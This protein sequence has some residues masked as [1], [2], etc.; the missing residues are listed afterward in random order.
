MS[1]P[2]NIFRWAM[3]HAYA[4]CAMV[5]IIAS[6]TKWNAIE[7]FHKTL[8]YSVIIPEWAVSVLTFGVPFIELWIGCWLISGIKMKWAIYTALGLLL[9]L[10]AY[11]TIERFQ[12]N[13]VKCNCLGELIAFKDA[14]SEITFGI[15]RNFV[16]SIGLLASLQIPA[17]RPQEIE[18]HAIP[19]QNTSKSVHA[20]FTLVELL[21][22]IGV[23]AVLL[24]LLL[25]ALAGFRNKAR[26]SACT[27][28]LR[29]IG[30]GAITWASGHRGFVSLDAQVRI[31]SMQSSEPR[32]VAEQLFDPARQRYMYEGQ[33]QPFS[34][35]SGSEQPVPFLVSLV[36][37]SVRKSLSERVVRTRQWYDVEKEVTSTRMLRCPDATEA[38][39]TRTFD[40]GSSDGGPSLLVTDGS[41]GDATWFYWSDYATNGAFLAFSTAPDSTSRRMRGLLTRVRNP[42]SFVLCADAKGPPT[43]NWYSALQTT[44]PTN[45]TLGQTI[46]GDVTPTWRSTYSKKRHRG[47]VNVLLVDGHVASRNSGD[48]IDLILFRA[49]R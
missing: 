40:P 44:E 43:V 47:M 15:V 2:G 26:I 41:L 1:A 8:S 33:F 4:L 24:G 34:P 32:T 21:V 48:L 17:R 25:P 31:D 27:Q 49:D 20:G 14:R 18:P 36:K 11:L 29:Q 3:R 13:P 5:L 39:A 28:N 42:S 37:Q 30:Q 45:I 19:S 46:G 12:A 38:E 6:I 16:I 9:A 7:G 23:I 35:G 10:S 22:V